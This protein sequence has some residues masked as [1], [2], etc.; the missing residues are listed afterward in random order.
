MNSMTTTPINLQEEY[1]NTEIAKQ[2]R[3]DENHEK[4]YM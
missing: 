1:A 2:H 3:K 4:V